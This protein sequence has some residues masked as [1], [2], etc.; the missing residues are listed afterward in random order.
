MLQH[1]LS[2]A[3]GSIHVADVG[4]AYL[5]KA[6]P[7]QTLIDQGLCSLSAFEPDARE[8]DALRRHLGDFA[9]V[10][11]D[12]LGDGH[13][14]IL[15]VCHEGLGMNSLLEPDPLALGFSTLSPNG[16]ESRQ[17]SKFLPDGLTISTS[18]P[19]SII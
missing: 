5:E 15:Y 6:P 1:M 11:A 19:R 9:T 4:A 8:T 17:P 16:A 12:A 10:F 2:L 7:Y 14:H 18:F 13:E 3:E